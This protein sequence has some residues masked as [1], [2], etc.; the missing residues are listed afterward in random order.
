[1]AKD[2]GRDD[3]MGL[4]RRSVLWASL[5]AFV[6]ALSGGRR[7]RGA[8]ADRSTDVTTPGRRF[9]SCR[10]SPNHRPSFPLSMGIPIPSR[11]LW[12]GLAAAMTL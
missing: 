12:G 6:P 1:M 9:L 2:H 10:F 4:P 8:S 5:A 11:T 3:R 7:A